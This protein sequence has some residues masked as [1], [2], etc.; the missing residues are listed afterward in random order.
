MARLDE[1]TTIS[2][3]VMEIEMGAL[4]RLIGD[5][6]YDAAIL[7]FGP[8]V[9]RSTAA[10]ALAC[11][12]TDRMIYTVDHF[13]GK[14]TGYVQAD[15]ET[16]R[17][18]I[19]DLRLGEYVTIIVGDSTEVAL[20]WEGPSPWLVFHD[21]SHLY[22]KVKA[23]IL[24]ILPHIEIGGYFCFHDYTGKSEGQRGVKQAAD[25]LLGKPVKV[26]PRLGIFGITGEESGFCHIHSA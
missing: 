6:P 20:N 25:E 5:L 2:G 4:Q 3:Q 11:V 26:W 15:L 1:W 12:G 16:L 14:E 10:M 19:A 13:T 23:D 18:N 17:S 7:E 21:G 22:E 24:A 9:G 8:C